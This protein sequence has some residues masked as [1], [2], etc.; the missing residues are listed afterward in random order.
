MPTARLLALAALALLPACGTDPSPGDDVG[1]DAVSGPPVTIDVL[2]LCRDFT[3]LDRFSDGRQTRV[4]NRYAVVDGITPDTDF[5]VETCGLTW[6]PPID[7]CSAGATCTGTREPVG[8]R[9]TRSRQSGEFLDGKL[10]IRCGQVTEQFAVG[11]GLASRSEFRY[12][13]IRATVH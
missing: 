1:P 13:A 2:P 10:L 5:T 8:P 11:G 12:D 3:R 9:C 7:A 6:S 4:T